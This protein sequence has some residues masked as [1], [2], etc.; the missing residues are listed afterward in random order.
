MLLELKD[1]VILYVKGLRVMMWLYD[2]THIVIYWIVEKTIADEVDEMMRINACMILLE[3][4]WMLSDERNDIVN[5]LLWRLEATFSVCRHDELV[6]FYPCP[7]A[8]QTHIRG[9]A[10]AITS[11]KV[12]ACVLQHVL[13]IDTCLEIFVC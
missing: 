13:Y 3:I 5:L 12:I 9:I 1:A 11:V 8:V 10:Q 7:I 2:V 6:A 4:V